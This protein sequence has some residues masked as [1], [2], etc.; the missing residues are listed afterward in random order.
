[1]ALSRQNLPVLD[2]SGAV[3]D[4]SRGAYVLAPGDDAAIIATGA[5][6]EVAVAAREQL[7]QHG[8]NARVVS[9]PS[10]ELFEAQDSGYRHTVLPAD[11]PAVSVEAGV[12]LGWTKY[13]RRHIGVDRFGASAPGGEVLR[14]LGITPEATAQAVR[15]VLG[16][17]D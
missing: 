1:M 17:Q 8:L 5:E 9:M 13:S 15:D 12:S 16:L 6:V 11:L 10:W 4:L 7:A 2:R 14:R 3:G